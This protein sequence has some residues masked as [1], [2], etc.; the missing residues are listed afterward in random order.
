M[1][2]TCTT[3]I[4]LNEVVLFYLWGDM[5]LCT[6]TLDSKSFRDLPVKV[7]L[8]FTQLDTRQQILR[9]IFSMCVQ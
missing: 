8:I 6:R 9:G 7:T 1:N 2:A 5:E 4:Y 3:L